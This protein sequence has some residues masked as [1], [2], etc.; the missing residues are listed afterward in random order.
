MDMSRA[1]PDD[2]SLPPPYRDP[3]PTLSQDMKHFNGGL[4]AMVQSAAFLCWASRAWE[5]LKAGLFLGTDTVV[6]SLKPML[7]NR[8]VN[9]EI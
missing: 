1:L 5:D 6:E 8:S 9:W 2:K 4:H 7:R 3:E